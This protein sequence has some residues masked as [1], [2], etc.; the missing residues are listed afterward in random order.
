MEKKHCKVNRWARSL[1]FSIGSVCTA[2]PQFH[3]SDFALY[4]YDGVHLSDTS[5]GYFRANLREC[6][7]SIFAEKSNFLTVIDGSIPSPVICL[8]LERRASMLQ[9]VP[10][11]HV[12]RI[13]QFLPG[14]DVQFPQINRHFGKIVF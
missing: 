2:H 6:I 4:H 12:W 10:V 3:W 8:I 1:G 5:N 14:S 9:V 7:N 11:G 13:W